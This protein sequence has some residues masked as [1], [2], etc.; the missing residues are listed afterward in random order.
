LQEGRRTSG[1]ARAFSGLAL[2]FALSFANFAGLALTVLGLGGFKGWT[3]VQFFGFYG[4]VEASAGLANLFLPNVWH[5]PV[6]ETETSARTRI[7]LAV[8][9]FA[10]PHW[11]ASARVVSGVVMMGV[12]MSKEGVDPTALLIPIAVCEIALIFFAWSAAAS[13]AGVAWPHVDVIKIS[14]DWLGRKRELPPVSLGASLL[15]FLWSILTLPAIYIFASSI[16]YRPK[17]GL[18]PEAMLWL[19][20]GCVLAVALMLLCWWGRIAWRAPRE[21]QVKVEQ[22]A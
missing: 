11:G 1:R 6:V 12:A 21:Q 4:L 5:L 7:K 14:I 10:I 9:S 2:T 18:D 8:S 15:Q 22:T 3:A 19:T 16:L 20:V 17:M 13:R